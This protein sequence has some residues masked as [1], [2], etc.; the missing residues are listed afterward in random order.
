M[1]AT[2]LLI[3]LTVITALNVVSSTSCCPWLSCSRLLCLRT[4]PEVNPSINQTID[5]R[6]PLFTP[7][8]RL[9]LS[10]SNISPT[11]HMHTCTPFSSTLVS[12]QIDDFNSID[13]DN[14][15][16]FVLNKTTNTQ[17]ERIQYLRDSINNSSLIRLSLYSNNASNTDALLLVINGKYTIFDSIR[18]N[19]EN[20]E[21]INKLQ[22]RYRNVLFIEDTSSNDGIQTIHVVRPGFIEFLKTLNSITSSS[23]T[24]SVVL[25]SEAIAS[26]EIGSLLSVL[27]LIEMHYNKSPHFKGKALYFEGV[28][29][30]KKMKS[31]SRLRHF[32]PFDLFFKIIIVDRNGLSSWLDLAGNRVGSRQI[33]FLQA[34]CF[35]ITDINDVLNDSYF[36][37]TNDRIFLQYLSWLCDSQKTLVMDTKIPHEKE[38]VS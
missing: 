38:R 7:P 27:A 36:R 12:K 1:M 35:R 33:V 13:I 15:T 17:Q 19:D 37:T 24:L 6:P 26:K 3:Y 32:I 25:Y 16:T 5:Q 21:I 28:I 10:S 9:S 18:I 34:P 4:Q 14:E 30:E 11:P 31:I 20:Q 2:E 23:S 8:I 22:N 29:L